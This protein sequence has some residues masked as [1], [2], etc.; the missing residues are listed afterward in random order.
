MSKT[1]LSTICVWHVHSLVSPTDIYL[2]E[3]LCD[4]T[5][6]ITGIRVAV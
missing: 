6:S 5:C 3:F 4:D 1:P 2:T